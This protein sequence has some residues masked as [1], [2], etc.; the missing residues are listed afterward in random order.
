MSAVVAVEPQVADTDDTPP[1][2]PQR[3]WH[4]G[5]CGPGPE[6]A[7]GRVT[8]K[9]GEPVRHCRYEAIN[10]EKATRPVIYCACTCHTDPQRAGQA[11]A[12]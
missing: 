3:P 7:D 5:F 11:T 9:A 12:R 8:N 10:G 2:K 6:C 4:S 1:S